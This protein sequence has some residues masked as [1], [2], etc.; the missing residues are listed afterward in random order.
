MIINHY[1]CRK[2][3]KLMD[4][5]RLKIVLVAKKKQASGWQNT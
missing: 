2:I 1:L 3:K 4:I 5:N